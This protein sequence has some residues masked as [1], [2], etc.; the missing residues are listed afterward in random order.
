MYSAG[1]LRVTRISCIYQS[2][3]HVTRCNLAGHPLPGALGDDEEHRVDGG[4][5]G[6]HFPAAGPYGEGA[7]GDGTEVSGSAARGR[8]RAVLDSGRSSL[9]RTTLLMIRPDV[10]YQQ[11]SLSR[12]GFMFDAL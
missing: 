9:V 2:L 5:A 6:R 1:H 7:G 12:Q 4:G 8:V 3:T 10:S 11:A